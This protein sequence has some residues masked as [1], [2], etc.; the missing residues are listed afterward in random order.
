MAEIKSIRLTLWGQVKFSAYPKEVV[1]YA[2][3]Q[4]LKKNLS[5]NKD[6]FLYLFAICKKRCEQQNIVTF[7]PEVLDM[8]REMKMPNEGPFFDPDYVPSKENTST[9]TFKKTSTKKTDPYQHNLEIRERYGNPN[10]ENQAKK[11]THE[12]EW[13]W[14]RQN[15]PTKFDRWEANAREFRAQI[16]L[17]EDGTFQQGRSPQEAVK[18]LINKLTP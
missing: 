14:T 5:I 3:Q 4:T 17:N 8:A 18:I 9:S 13:E 7:W 11:M 12:E 2:D 16:G 6:R 10:L 1:L 15:D